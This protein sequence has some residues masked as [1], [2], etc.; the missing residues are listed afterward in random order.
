MFRKFVRLEDTSLPTLRYCLLILWSNPYTAIP[1][2]IQHIHSLW[3]YIPFTDFTRTIITSF[4]LLIRLKSPATRFF[5]AGAKWKSVAPG[6]TPMRSLLS[7]WKALINDLSGSYC[8]D[9]RMV[10]PTHIIWVTAGRYRQIQT[11]SYFRASLCD[12]IFFF[13][14]CNIL[15]KDFRT[16]GYTH[17]DNYWIGDYLKARYWRWSTI[18]LKNS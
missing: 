9:F 11:I 17:T 15:L 7:R 5:F 12:T 4:L 14:P 16:Q 3:H 6:D 18:E 8:Q 2:Q 13:Y 1:I 10:R